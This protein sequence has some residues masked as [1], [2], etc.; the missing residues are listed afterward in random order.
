M[1][2]ETERSRRRIGR[3]RVGQDVLDERHRPMT[4]SAQLEAWL[5]EF[6]LQSRNA[7][8]FDR[9]LDQLVDFKHTAALEALSLVR[10]AH[11]AE[12]GNSSGPGW[13]D[14]VELPWWVVDT[15]GLIYDRTRLSLFQKRSRGL[16]RVFGA[17]ARGPGQRAPLN[18]PTWFFATKQFLDTCLRC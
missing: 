15:L 17:S 8:G 4:S 12:S 7:R 16:R 9:S 18:G 6:Q 2:S 10:R 3:I 11:L 14:T 13:G 1:K 5:A